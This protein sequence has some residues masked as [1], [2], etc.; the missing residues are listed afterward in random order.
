MKTTAT[1][2]PWN[3]ENKGL[4]DYQIIG[5]RYENIGTVSRPDMASLIVKAVNSHEA[6]LNALNDIWTHSRGKCECTNIDDCNLRIEDIT[7]E[8]IKQAE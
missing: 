7:R 5:D 8:A 2:R 3:V 6:L 1:A 4:G